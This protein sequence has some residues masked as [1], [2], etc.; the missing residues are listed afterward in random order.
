MLGGTTTTSLLG[1]EPTCAHRAEGLVL[2][3]FYAVDNKTHG[4]PKG[5]VSP[6]SLCL[7]ARPGGAGGG[8]GTSSSWS[9]SFILSQ[10]R[11]EAWIWRREV[12]GLL[13]LRLSGGSVYA[14]PSFAFP[15]WPLPGC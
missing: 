12:E 13:P 8:E 15:K 4:K 9:S 3:L 1:E 14:F 5:G 6:T 10:S 7:A 11:A 2:V